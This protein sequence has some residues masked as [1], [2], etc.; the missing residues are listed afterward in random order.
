[1]V[2]QLMASI[3]KSSLIS[4]YSVYIYHNRET[5]LSSVQ[6]FLAGPTGLS[7]LSVGS[8]HW[9]ESRVDTERQSAD[10]LA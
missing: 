2:A 10:K 9:H 3:T 8:D 4:G 1:M 6:D 5:A 7:S